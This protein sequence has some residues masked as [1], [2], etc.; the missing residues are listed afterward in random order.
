M[1]TKQKTRHP[2]NKKISEALKED[3]SLRK[4]SRGLID[5]KA[6]LLS[7]EK[8]HD[9]DGEV[10]ATSTPT[11]EQLSKI[12]EFTRRDVGVDDVVVLPTLSCNDII[13]RDD[14]QFT[15]ECVKEFS[16]LPQPYSPVGKSYMLD[17]SRSVQQAVGRIFDVG[18]KKIEGNEFL[19]NDVYVPNTEKN[20][21]FIEDVD[22]GINWA[23]SVGVVIGKDACTVCGDRF[24][25]FGWWCVNGHD[26]GLF[27][28]PDEDETDNFGFPLPTEE[29][30]PKAVKCVR[31]YM[32]PQDFYELSQV[33]L[34]AQYYAALEEKDPG[35]SGILKAASAKGVPVVG[36]SADEAKE[37]PLRHEPH[38]VT[39]A[40]IGGHLK[41]TP[42]GLL[43]WKDKQGLVRVYNPHDPQEGVMS[44]GKSNEED[45][46]K[47]KEEDNGSEGL[48]EHASGG[49]SSG[50]GN[51]ASGSE[52]L[53]ES[54]R[55][56]DP[57]SE[58][59]STESGSSGEAVP[60]VEDGGEEGA[61]EATDIAASV[62]EGAGVPS[63]VVS[64]VVTD[65]GM[66]SVK[67]LLTAV[68]DRIKVL[69]EEKQ[70]LEAKAVLGTKYIEGLKTDA[71][72]WYVK[73]HQEKDGRPVKTQ[74]FERLVD[75]C[76]DDAELIKSIIDEQREIAQKRFPDAVRR[77]TFPENPHTVKE[78]EETDV[79]TSSDSRVSR[80]HQ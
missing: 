52:E 56:S 59:G 5:K 63:D 60:P 71:I 50:D 68:G 38:E 12:N 37:I 31:Q 32:D 13:D 55:G 70:A 47:K 64:S 75:R 44:L 17:H 15:T 1:T 46:D 10:G 36:L 43:M 23:V 58:S 30:N 7:T 61:S 74:T 65:E 54:D 3:E 18:T 77:S 57:G 48:D 11:D 34:G 9:G 4:S 39:D 79:D 20:R 26:K 49:S 35:F 76:G 78:E 21:D 45:G 19:I 53:P 42:D 41:E 67:S 69:Q 40:R 24:S 72:D 80:L 73:S 16:E 25:Y 2:Q 28:D 22:Y 14:D 66:L 62:A 33:F 51:P 8:G 6:T 27:Y 29:S